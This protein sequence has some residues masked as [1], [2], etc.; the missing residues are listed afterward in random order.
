MGPGSIDQLRA[1]A[2]ALRS[3]A[4]SAAVFLASESDG[5]VVLL[6]AMTKD[7]TARGIKAGELMKSA[8][9]IVGGR[10]GG[11]PDMAQGGGPDASKIGEVVQHAAEWLRSAIAS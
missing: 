2:D 9:P 10:G 1:A 7:L 8:A 4:G 6:A 5:K 11:R 3:R